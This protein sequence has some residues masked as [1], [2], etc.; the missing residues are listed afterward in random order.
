MALLLFFIEVKIALKHSNSW[1]KWHI[2]VSVRDV[3][4]CI[5]NPTSVT[6]P[7]QTIVSDIWIFC[8]QT[9]K[10]I[11]EIWDQNYLVYLKPKKNKRK[12]VSDFLFEVSPGWVTSW[13]SDIIR[14]RLRTA[15]A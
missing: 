13:M 3:F 1:H 11:K 9:S 15:H 12:I 2:L 6:I 10:T 5:V 8:G 4:D 14:Q 7:K